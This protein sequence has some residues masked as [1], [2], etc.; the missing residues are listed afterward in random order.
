MK[1]KI[2]LKIYLFL[3]LQKSSKSSFLLNDVLSCKYLKTNYES[4]QCWY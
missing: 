2:N 4:P 3:F 1:K